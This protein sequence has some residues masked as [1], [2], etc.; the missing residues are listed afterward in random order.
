MPEIDQMPSV[1]FIGLDESI[2]IVD[3]ENLVS[4]PGNSPP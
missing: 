2:S 4:Q 3:F 1:F